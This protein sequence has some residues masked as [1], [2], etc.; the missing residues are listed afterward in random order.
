MI[1]RGGMGVVYLA[2]DTKLDRS[3]AVK[4]IPA[5]LQTDSTTRARFNREAKLLASLSHPNISVIHEIIEEEKSGYLILEYVPGETLTRHIAAE[6][7]KLQEVLS[8]CRQVA[9]AVS[10]AHEKGVIHRDLKPGNIKITPDGKVKV[11]DFGLAKAHA[12][13]D[14]G[15]DI[16]TSEPGH[17]IGTPAYMS[18]EQARSKNMDHRTDIWS[19]GCIMFQ[20]LTGRLPFEGE[21]ATDTLAHIIEREPDWELLPKNTPANIRTLLRRCLEKDP[22]RR[23]QHIGDAAIEIGETLTLSATARLLPAPVKSRKLAA[24]LLVIVIA[25]S[26][27]AV[28]FGPDR[29]AQPPSKLKMLAV[30]PFINVGPD[31]DEY[32]ADGMTAEITAGLGYIRDLGVMSRQATTKYKN[33]QESVQQIGKDLKVEYILAGTIQ[34]EQPSDPNSRVTMRLELIRASDGTQAWAFTYDKPM[35]DIFQLQSSIA[36]EVAEALGVA[37]SGEQPQAPTEN[38]EARKY[39]LRGKQYRSMTSEFNDIAIQMFEKAIVL[40]PNF[41]LAYVELGT[42]HLNICWNRSAALKA[43]HQPKAKELIDRAFELDPDL[44]EVLGARIQYTYQGDLDYDRALDECEA[45]LERW[46]NHNGAMMIMGFIYK[47]QGKFEQA[48]DLIER[49]SRFNPNSSRQ[50]NLAIILD[51]LRKYPEAMEALNLAI[52]L[53]PRPR[54][55]ADSRWTGSIYLQG[56]GISA[57]AGQN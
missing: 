16:T 52:S 40:D 46:P 25:L 8:I 13:E 20:M 50:Y 35:R 3:V 53:K 6:P 14:K 57:L 55:L 2:H 42:L 33:T 36:E 48:A 29:Q 51:F 45:V 18:P 28:L 7:L 38:W 5:E 21:T 43:E 27:F 32:F 39:Y 44:P 12:S 11:L 1:G 37:F 23:L 17:V 10:A 31:E 24:V 4:G 22:Q 41:A 49:V 56:G 47:R 34:R 54:H 9:E 19:F 30:L 15:G 26:I